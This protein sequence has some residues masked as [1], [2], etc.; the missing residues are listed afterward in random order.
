MGG[1]R[2]TM[3]SDRALRDQRQDRILI[4]LDRG[5]NTRVV[6]KQASKAS[7]MV[8]ESWWQAKCPKSGIRK[9]KSR[10]RN[11]H[12]TTSRRS[13]A[14]TPKTV[15]DHPRRL[16]MDYPPPAPHN[17]TTFVMEAHDMVDSTSP[18]AEWPWLDPYDTYCSDEMNLRLPQL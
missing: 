18:V 11:R 16:H 4:V 7:P 14:K 10:R 13:L 1:T 3:C 12:G 15:T 5:T 6:Y 17:T 9:D 2:T 8:G